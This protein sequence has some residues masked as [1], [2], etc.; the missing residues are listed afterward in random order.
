MNVLFALSTLFAASTTV[1]AQQEIVGG[2]EAAVGQHLYVTGFRSTETGAASCGSSLIAPNVV[3]TAAHCIGGGRTFVSIGSHYKSGTKDGE[4]IK[5]KQAIK[6]PKYN[7]GTTSYDFAILI[8]EQPSKFPPVQVSFDTVA[9]GTPSIV[10]GWGRTSSGGASSEVLL[11]VGVNSISNDQCAKLLTGFTVNEAML[12]AGGKLGEDSCQGDSGGPLTVESNG[13]VKLV[14]VVSWGIGCAQQDKPG[15]YS[16]ISIA[17]DFIEPFITTSPTAVP[18]TTKPSAAPTVSPVTSK[19]P[20]A[21]PITTNPTAA[22]I[23]TA[24]V[25]TVVPTVAP[26]TASPSK[27]NGC[28]TCFYPTLNYCFPPAYTKTICESYASLGAFWCGN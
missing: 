28:S 21:A 16:R 5:V 3:L 9:P 22:P 27:C 23:T 12:C 26:T 25:P 8:L 14:G 1:V 11:E 15:V 4:R 19:T 10:R 18:I 2:T 13:S 17:R 6:H 7:A 24:K 20:T